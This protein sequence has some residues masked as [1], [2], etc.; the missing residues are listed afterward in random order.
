MVFHKNN[1]ETEV[2]QKEGKITHSHMLH[3]SHETREQNFTPCGVNSKL[4][5][6]KIILLSK[7]KKPDCKI[8]SAT[9]SLSGFRF[10]IQ[11]PKRS[12]LITRN[13]HLIPINKIVN[14]S[15]PIGSVRLLR[16]ADKYPI[17]NRFFPR[18]TAS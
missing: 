18:K 14:H 5:S 15:R 7:R 11:L 16:S 4:Q 13:N 10:A 6:T 8:Y 2:S 9:T 3:S 17:Q 1:K 12:F